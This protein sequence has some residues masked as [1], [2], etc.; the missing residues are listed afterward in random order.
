MSL[1]DRAEKLKSDIPTVFLSLKDKDT[2]LYTKIAAAATVGYALSPIDFIPDFIPV[3]GYLDDIILLPVF[4]AVTIKLIPNE[5]W[6]RNHKL[7]RHLWENGR[8]RKWYCAIP[9]VLIWLLLLWLISS[10]LCF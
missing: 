8:P 9:I 4:V 3:L 7:A 1:K 10:I 5:V 2:P 6:E